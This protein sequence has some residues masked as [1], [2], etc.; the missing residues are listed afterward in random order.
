MISF[1]VIVCTY[2][3]NPVIFNRCLQAILYASVKTCPA[4]I[5][6]VDNNSTEPVANQP[7]VKEWLGTAKNAS[8]IVEKKQGLT[9]A[10]L[11][12]IKEATGEL[13][14]FIDDDNI[15]ATDFF[16]KG[17]DVASGNINIGAWSG[18]VLLEFEKKPEPW[19]EKYWGLLVYRAFQENRWSNLPHLEDTMP[20]GAG[21]FIR[22]KVADYYYQLHETGKRDIQLDRN[23]KSLFSGGDNDMAACACD[24]GMGVGLFYEIVVTHYIPSF[25]VEKKYLLELA[26]GIAASTIVFKSFRNE[27]PPVLSLKNKLANTI[28]LALK[29]KLDREFYAAVLRGEAYGREMLLNK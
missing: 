17:A 1:S 5:I 10:R 12:G 29:N 24:L 18:Q 19:T 4:E 27:S 2:N 21:L 26:G 6:I 15:I 3:P 22:K 14:I 28:R 25:R 11:L 9:P 13:L 7:Y 20:C 23:G 8:V 16:R